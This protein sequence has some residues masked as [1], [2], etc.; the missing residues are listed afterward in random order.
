ME[1]DYPIQPQLNFILYAKPGIQSQIRHLNAKSS[2]LCSST[3]KQRAIQN[4]INQHYQIAP[5]FSLFSTIQ[6]HSKS[7]LWSGK[8]PSQNERSA[9]RSDHATKQR[10]V[11]AGY[12]Q[13]VLTARG[14]RERLRPMVQAYQNAEIR[15][16]FVVYGAA[17]RRR[18]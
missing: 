7:C 14:T 17:K 9:Q 11:S 8:R 1:L 12:P 3:S 15:A 6:R 10:P 4:L 16:D 18:K 2:W 5:N 13:S